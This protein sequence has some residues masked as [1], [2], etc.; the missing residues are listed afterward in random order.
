MM[1]SESER[2]VFAAPAVRR[3]LLKDLLHALKLLRQ[4]RLSQ[5]EIGTTVGCA[6]EIEVYTLQCSFIT[7]KHFKLL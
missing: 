3:N 5:R 7:T 2:H 1:H 6:K 4:V